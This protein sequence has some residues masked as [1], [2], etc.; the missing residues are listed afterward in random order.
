MPNL[1]RADGHG[2]GISGCHSEMPPDNQ[3]R[4]ETC[5]YAK[6]AVDDNLFQLKMGILM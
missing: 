4:L 3:G 5:P 1:I 6:L 2:R